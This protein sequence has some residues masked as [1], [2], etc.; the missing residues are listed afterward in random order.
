MHHGTYV[1][2]QVMDHVGRYEFNQCVARRHGHRG[3]RRLSCW[4]QFLVMAFGQLAGRESLRDAVVCLHA[5]REKLYHLGIRAP[6]VRTTIAHANEHRDWRIWSDL[7]ATLIARARPLYATDPAFTL[8]LDGAVYLIDATTIDLCLSVFPWA[9]FRTTKGA[10]KCNV[11][12]D[13]RGH[14]P[15]FF[16]I[17]TGNV[18][19]V[20]FLDQVAYEV[21]AHYIMDRG[22]TD[23]ERLYR[24]HHAGA[25]FVIRAKDNLAFRRVYSR[26]VDK[27]TGVG[28]DQIIRLT[29]VRTGGVYP[30]QIRRIVYTDAE[31][32]QR[33]VFLTNDVTADAMTVAALYK[34]RWQIELFFKWI[35]QYLKIR[36]FWGHSANAVKTQLC[37]AICTYLIVA[38]LKQERNMGRSLYEILQ[39]VSVSLFDKTPIKTLV[40]AF[41]LPSPTDRAQKLPFLLGI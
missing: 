10:V 26:P 39:I 36:A 27:A 19:D 9:H 5:H 16:D 29:G 22:Y 17:S 38:I 41:D 31:T 15:V 3:V 20:H 18:H 13:V 23:F 14:I 1:F 7:A 21:G 32:Q 34:Y 6:L 8:D 35:K 40:S 24:I 28:C 2:A 30:E 37:I 25:F 33:Y 12:I 4:D 11:Q